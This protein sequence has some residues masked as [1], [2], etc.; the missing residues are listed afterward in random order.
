M[1]TLQPKAAKS[2]WHPLRCHAGGLTGG[3]IKEIKALR[4]ERR[5]S[6]IQRSDYHHIYPWLRGE[7]G[8]FVGNLL[9]IQQLEQEGVRVA[10]LDKDQEARTV[11][12]FHSIG[13][14]GNAIDGNRGMDAR[15][16]VSHNDAVIGLENNRVNKQ[17][18]S[19]CIAD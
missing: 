11:G 19:P 2:A 18:G 4:R 9:C 5:D 1:P 17:I 15:Q 3:T 12:V 6:T 7:I 8:D 16:R 10:M 14:R 13:V